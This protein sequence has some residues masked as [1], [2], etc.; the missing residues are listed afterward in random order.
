M[1]ERKLGLSQAYI[2]VILMGAGITVI[3]TLPIPAQTLVWYRVAI[4]AP[5]LALYALLSRQS[6][7]VAKPYRLPLI[8]TAL[9]TGGHWVTLFIS[10]HLS[11]V[12]IGMI[13]F[14]SFPIS[15]T[16]FE[17]ALQRRKPE[18]RDLTISILILIGVILLTPLTGASKDLLPGV[19]MGILSGV[20][21]AGRMVLIRHQLRAVS[22]LTTMFWSMI[23][24][25][26]ALS[27]FLTNSTPPLALGILRS[28]RRPFSWNLRHRILPHPFT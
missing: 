22:G 12:A 7:K 20:L 14:Y 28:P 6:L 25:M 24:M 15:T 17:A 3:Q 16:V 2:A 26:V 19:L 23:V 9:L 5:G 21:W 4:A 1:N 11:S 8:W 27:P 10:I 18:M 13:S